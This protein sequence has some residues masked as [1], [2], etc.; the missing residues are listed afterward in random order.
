MDFA[1]RHQT[2]IRY[3]LAGAF[4][5]AVGL[6]VYPALY[7]LAL[8][9]K[10]HYLMILTISQIICVTVAFL[11]NKFVV[12]RT[13]GNFLREFLKFVSFH[14]SYFL[15]NL[16]A[17]PALVELAGMNPVWAQTIFAVLVIIT[18]YFW[19]SRITFSS[20]KVAS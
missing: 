9:L 17:L 4:N 7:F 3:L 15:V 18:S 20:T 14:V 13:S 6:A 2:K 11:T 8:P 19:H 12:F 10:L 5:T 16:A 1:K